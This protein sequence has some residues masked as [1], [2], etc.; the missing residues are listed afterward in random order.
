LRA[1]ALGCF[2]ADFSFAMLGLLLEAP[3]TVPSVI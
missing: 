3:L 2:F 1:S